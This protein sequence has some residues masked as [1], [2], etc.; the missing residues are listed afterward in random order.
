LFD[1][2]PF[3]TEDPI[4]YLNQL[5]IKRNITMAEIGMDSMRMVA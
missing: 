3:N 1:D 2:I 4:A 5:E